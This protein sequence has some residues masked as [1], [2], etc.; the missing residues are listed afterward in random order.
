MRHLFH[1]LKILWTARLALFWPIWIVI[2]CAGILLVLY[3]LRNAKPL[4]TSR[5]LPQKWSLVDKL[6]VAVLCIVLGVCIAG[7]LVWDDFTYYDNSHFTDGTLQ[8]RDVEL[9][10]SSETGRFWPLGYQE[11]NLTRHVTHSSDGYHLP[12][13]VELLVLCG[14]LLFFDQRLGIRVRIGLILLVLITPGILISFDGLIYPESNVMLACMCLIWSVRRFEQ[15]HKRS[16]AVAAL[17]CVQLMLYY[18][19]ICLLLLLGITIGR[20]L[21][22]CRQGRSNGWSFE[23]LRDPESRLD[24]CLA[25]MA[26]PFLCYY[27]AAMFPVFGRAYSNRAHLPLSTVLITSFKLDILVWVFAVVAV[28]RLVFILQGRVRAS[29]TWDGLALGGIGVLAGYLILHMSSGYYLAPVDLI[30]VIYLGHFVFLSIQRLGYGSRVAVAF[31]LAAVLLQDLSLSAFRLYENKNVIHSK[32]EMGSWIKM[33]YKAEPYSVTE[34]YF[35]SASPFQILEFAAYLNYLG[36]P[37]EQGRLVVQ[38]APVVKLRGRQVQTDGPCG[39][40]AFICHRGEEPNP[41]DLIIAFP[42]DQAVSDGPVTNQGPKLLFSYEPYPTIPPWLEG[43][44]KH[45][46]VVSPEF[47][48]LPLPPNWLQASI[49][50]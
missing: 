12:R 22:R 42:D 5:A 47:A 19:E 18:K 35:P 29:V 20:L 37:V 14:I 49:T 41:G 23:R 13:I 2:T 15:G 11:F 4:R 10:I 21:S 31:V 28:T 40:R 6:L 43:Y 33:R 27:L 30:A 1:P 44:V 9:Q 50:E 3:V 16:W 7:T 24:L 26:I 48:Y 32:A 34:L 25:T 45:L 17:I 39:Y 46:H 8:G 38:R 36:V